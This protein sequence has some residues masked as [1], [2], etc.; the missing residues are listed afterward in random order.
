MVWIEPTSSCS[1]P[2]M[3][4]WTRQFLWVTT[5]GALV[6]VSCS[7]E[8]STDSTTTAPSATAPASSTV[9]PTTST[10]PSTVPPT[11][12][13]VVRE[14]PAIWP[15]ADVVFEDPEVAASDFVAHVLDVPIALGDFAAADARSG[16]I[17][18]SCDLCSGT[19]RGTL[20]MR[21]LGPSDGWFVTAIVNDLTTITSPTQGDAVEPGPITVSGTAIGFE[22]N[23]SITAFVVG[24]AARVLDRVTVLAGTMGEAGPFSVTL[25]LS[26]AA[27]GDVIVLLVRGGVGLETDP[28]DIA[29][30]AVV[31]G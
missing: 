11:T 23:V 29:A 16:E 14:Q 28:G 24:D 12:G 26:A 8:S 4:G 30:V 18:V 20:L 25:D 21:R 6:T 3:I 15:A 5:I 27:P 1:R 10:P 2:R 19:P 7:S 22:A 17:V 31:V 13:P 9:A